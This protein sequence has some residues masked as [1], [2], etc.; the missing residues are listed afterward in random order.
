MVTLLA[1]NTD[2]LL[3]FTLEVAESLMVLKQTSEGTFCV[4]NS[5]DKML[6]FDSLGVKPG[7]AC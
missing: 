5:R 7:S 4:S 6:V 3:G 1:L 2:Y